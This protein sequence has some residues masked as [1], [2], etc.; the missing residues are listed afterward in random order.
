M[1]MIMC[2]VSAGVAEQADALD[3]KSNEPRGSYRFDS[4]HRHQRDFVSC[5]QSPYIKIV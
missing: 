4:G 2:L 1:V 3:L 5:T